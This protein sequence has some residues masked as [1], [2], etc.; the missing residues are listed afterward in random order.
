MNLSPAA[1]IPVIISLSIS[2][3]AVTAAEEKGLD[4]LG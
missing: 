3:S 1:V 4:P 2:F